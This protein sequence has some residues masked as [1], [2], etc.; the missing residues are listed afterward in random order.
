MNTFTAP[1]AALIKKS[2]PQG[3]EIVTTYGRSDLIERAIATLKDTLIEEMIVVSLV[4]M[5]FLLHFRSSLIAILTLPIAILLAFT[6]LSIQHMTANIMSL[7]GIAVAS[8]PWS[9]RLSP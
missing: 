5:A 1:K 8:A 2:L 7:G 3:V 4:I 6:P 9:M